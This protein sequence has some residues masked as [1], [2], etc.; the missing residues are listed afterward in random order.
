MMCLGSNVAFVLLA[1]LGGGDLP[2]TCASEP[3]GE[4]ISFK[5]IPP[6]EEEENSQLVPDEYRCQACKGVIFQITEALRQVKP[7]ELAVLKMEGKHAVQEQTAR[8]FEALENACSSR[9]YGDYGL[10]A[11]N[12]KNV[13]HGP[14]IE[15]EGPGLIQTGGRWPARMRM[16]CASLLE[17][18]GEYDLLAHYHAGA[19]P[20]LCAEDCTAGKKKNRSARRK[21]A[22]ETP[23][24]EP[25]EKTKQTAAAAAATGLEDLPAPPWMCKAVER[26]TLDAFLTKEAKQFALVV[27]HDVSPGSARA[28]HIAELVARALAKAKAKKVRNVRVA[29]YNSTSGDTHGYEF[30]R[31]PAIVFFRKGYRNPKMYDASFAGPDE[32]T[33]W[34]GNEVHNVYMKDDPEKF[35]RLDTEF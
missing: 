28:L 23:G 24:K 27:F 1:V 16:R 17:D 9:A 19:L 3:V 29:R 6:T 30:H 18:V 10:K 25:K 12:G 35:P 26:A 13:F 21:R 14:G 7:R 4:R 11:I 20:R 34:I 22:V 8:V 5:P 2:C 15:T 33:A 31:L 32:V